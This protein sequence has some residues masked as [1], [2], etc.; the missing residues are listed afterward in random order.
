KS[1]RYN[2]SRSKLLETLGGA[3]V[4]ARSLQPFLNHPDLANVVIPCGDEQSIR[5]ALTSPID[6]RIQF[7]AGGVTRAHSVLAAL[8]RV[9]SNVEWVAVHDAARPLI[10]RELIDRTLAAA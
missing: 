2:S 6:P 10:S 5:E 9:P 4:I 7:C 1:T 3:S 8:Q